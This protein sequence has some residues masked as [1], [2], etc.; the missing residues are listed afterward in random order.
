MCLA[1]FCFL[2]CLLFGWGYILCHLKMGFDFLHKF[3]SKTQSLIGQAWE[4]KN[5]KGKTKKAAK[6]FKTSQGS[7]A[8]WGSYRRWGRRVGV[9]VTAFCGRRGR[10]AHFIRDVLTSWSR[11]GRVWIRVIIQFNYRIVQLIF[12]LF[13]ARTWPRSR[14]ATAIFVYRRGGVTMI[15]LTVLTDV[16]GTRGCGRRWNVVVMVM[17]MVMGMVMPPMMMIPTTTA[18]HPRR[19]NRGQAIKGHVNIPYRSCIDGSVCH[20]G[21]WGVESFLR[22]LGDC[23]AAGRC[24]SHMISI[25]EGGPRSW[26][27][28]NPSGLGLTPC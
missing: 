20:W 26:P 22:I 19:L 12:E 15:R 8:V 23:G 18:A 6:F 14:R 16:S 24:S 17:V 13:G 9:E 21:R 7:S 4:N 2:L 25:I 1:L 11:W 10:A 5:Q 28:W 27:D 3:I